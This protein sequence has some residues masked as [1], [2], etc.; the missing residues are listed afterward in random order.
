MSSDVDAGP[1]HPVVMRRMDSESGDPY[2]LEISATNPGGFVRSLW[3][4][5]SGS[6]HGNPAS[7]EEACGEWTDRMRCYRTRV[8][9]GMVVIYTHAWQPEGDRNALHPD[10]LRHLRRAGV[11]V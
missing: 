2:F 8:S 10:V 1:L 6:T 9:G 11:A 7:D 4:S 3:G 5:V